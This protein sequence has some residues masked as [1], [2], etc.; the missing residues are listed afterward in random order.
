VR[1]AVVGS[2]IT[3]LVAAWALSQPR[4]GEVH[5]VVLYEAA[6]RLGGHSHTIDAVV[7]GETVPVDTGFIVYN[8]RNYPHLIRIWSD[9]GVETEA[10]EMS[11]SVSVGGGAFEYSGSW[12][13]LIGQ[14]ANWGRPRYW[15]MIRDVMRFYRA[16]PGTLASLK[17]ARFEAAPKTLGNLISE[18]GYG[19]D[20]AERHILPMAAAIWSSNV[21]SILDFPAHTFLQFF[22]NHGL[23]SVNDRPQWRTISGGSRS[24]VA[25]MAARISGGV[26]LK[27]PVAHVERNA[28]G[29]TLV[30]GDGQRDGFDQLVLAT[31]PDQA[32]S[33][34]GT[35]AT[36]REREV[37]GHFRY[38]PN[39]AVVHTDRALMPRRK[40][41]WSSW[42]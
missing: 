23:F 2:G 12:R 1:I 27:A 24:Y 30:T 31:H 28:G 37:L 22:E 6:P 38:Q 8:T 34:L 25:K 29:V 17:D 16:A 32:L 13:G 9:L 18:G 3:G 19:A 26:R 21:R 15:K 5:E 40:S 20:F 33:I 35:G 7:G 36:P 14:P 39:A 42:N 41:L 4:N 11:F 10:S